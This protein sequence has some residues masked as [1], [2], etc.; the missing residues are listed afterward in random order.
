[1]RRFII[2]SPSFTGE[3]ELIYK[4]DG[5][6]ASIVLT[7]AGMNRAITSSFKNFAP[8]HISDIEKFKTTQATVIEESFEIS[9]DMFWE[10]YDQKHNK[11]RVLQLWE[12]LSKAAQVKA[13]YGIDAYNKHL[14]KNTWKSKA[15]PDTY[16][17][18]RLFENEWK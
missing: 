15:D 8:E 3:A 6:L 10:K 13:Y 18:N 5:M 7:N 1:M 17:R 4:D 11:Q 16:L 2:T 12:K 14:Q 9:F